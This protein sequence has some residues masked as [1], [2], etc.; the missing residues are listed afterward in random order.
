MA[1]ETQ[2]TQSNMPQTQEELDQDPSRVIPDDADS[3]VAA[4][5]TSQNGADN[6]E[7]EPPRFQPNSWSS[8]KKNVGQDDFDLLLNITGEIQA[9]TDAHIAFLRRAMRS[10]QALYLQGKDVATISKLGGKKDADTITLVIT[11]PSERAAVHMLNAIRNEDA[12][13]ISDAQLMFDEM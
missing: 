5:T 2:A 7:A 12:V 6:Q 4:G 3:A 11:N 8:S 1:T 9:P 10:K 13:S